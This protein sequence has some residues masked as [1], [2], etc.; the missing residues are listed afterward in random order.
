[1]RRVL[2]D[3]LAARP[4]LTGFLWGFAGML[5]AVAGVVA[6][7]VVYH[8]WSDHRALHV[9]VDFLNQHAGKINKLP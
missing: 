6:I 1:M 9:V 4:R 7:L 3:Q 5:T 2:A 8:L